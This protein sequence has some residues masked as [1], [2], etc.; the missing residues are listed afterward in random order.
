MTFCRWSPPPINALILDTFLKVIRDG[1]NTQMLTGFK[2]E[3]LAELSYTL[4]LCSTKGKNPLQKQYCVI[5][6]SQYPCTN[7]TGIQLTWQIGQFKNELWLQSCLLKQTQLQQCS[8]IF[9]N[10]FRH[11]AHNHNNW[12]TQCEEGSS[13]AQN[14][15]DIHIPS[16]CLKGTQVVK[17]I[18]LSSPTCPGHSYKSE[19]CTPNVT[20]ISALS[21]IKKSNCAKPI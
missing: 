3:I 20:V 11:L 1:F 4:I 6:H 17:S 16:L 15:Q 5:Q 21:P 7:F 19:A 10:N 12:S 9:N 18:S 2:L 13:R 14:Q 8:N